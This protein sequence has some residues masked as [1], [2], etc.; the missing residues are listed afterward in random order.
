M[1]GLVSV[2]AR[3]MSDRSETRYST[4]ASIFFKTGTERRCDTDVPTGAI[5]IE[6]RTMAANAG[7]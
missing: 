6:A 5:N 1:T 2:H 3:E 7:R 4:A